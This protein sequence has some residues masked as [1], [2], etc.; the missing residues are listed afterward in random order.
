MTLVIFIF[1][2]KKKMMKKELIKNL[3]NSIIMRN[4][5]KLDSYDFFRFRTNNFE[6]N[7]ILFKT[8]VIL[9]YS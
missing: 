3:K 2:I 6:N 8:K 1:K 7:S 5:N 4:I 9:Y